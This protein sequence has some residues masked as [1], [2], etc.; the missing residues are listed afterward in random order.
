VT[1]PVAELFHSN[2]HFH[3]SV[4]PALWVKL[5]D[6]GCDVLCTQSAPG[7]QIVYTRRDSA[8]AEPWGWAGC[9][10]RYAAWPMTLPT[11]LR[12][13]PKVRSD[14]TSRSTE[15]EASAA[16]IFAIRDWLEPSCRATCV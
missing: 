12:D 1:G 2:G 9:A 4:K 14:L 8:E 10:E 11:S 16:S 3:R 7:R 6:C 13:A 5:G 15:T